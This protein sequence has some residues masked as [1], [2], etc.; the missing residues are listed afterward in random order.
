MIN[1]ITDILKKNEF[2]CRKFSDEQIRSLRENGY[3]LIAPNK[4]I[5]DWID[6]DI[7]N[8]LLIIDNLIEKEGIDAGSEGKEEFSIKKNKPLED[9]AL[10]L[11]NLINKNFLMRKVATIPEII[12]GA[13]AVLNDE[14]K[15][16]SIIFREPIKNMGNQELHIDWLARESVDEKYGE[17][18]AMLYLDDSNI[19]NGATSVVPGSHK[20]LSYPSKYVNPKVEYKNEIIIEAK[21]GSLL[22]LNSNTWHRGTKNVS[23]KRRRI[24]NIDYRRRELKQLLNTK[25]YISE[26]IRNSLDE[27][28]KYLFGLREIDREQKEKSYGVGDH[29]REWLKK[30][31]KYNYKN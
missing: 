27:N 10:R 23:G 4:S 12:W 6:T 17:V 9:G 25:L 14:I 22:I 20:I 24:L 30:N 11:A 13:Y 18:K 5:F 28:E 2:Y 15:L 16:S 7:E 29:Y 21:A 19:S 31:P 8:L 1:S 26:E 3:L